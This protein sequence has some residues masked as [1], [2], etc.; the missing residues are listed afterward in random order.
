MH[1]SKFSNPVNSRTLS[2]LLS[3][4]DVVQAFLDKAV[5]DRDFDAADRINAEFSECLSALLEAAMV[6]DV[7]ELARFRQIK[8][9]HA[10]AQD[11]LAKI[12]RETRGRRSKVQAALSAYS[13]V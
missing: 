10:E 3:Y 12:L 2:D 11:A 6:P 1:G 9:R 13:R 8:A 4:L 5:L 7:T